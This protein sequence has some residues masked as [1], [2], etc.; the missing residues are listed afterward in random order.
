MGKHAGAVP[1]SD[2]GRAPPGTQD[3]AGGTLKAGKSFAL[4]ELCI[5]IAEGVPWFGR[6][7]V[8]Q[9]KVLY[10]NLE[11]DR[12]SCFH[13]FRDVYTAMELNPENLRNIDVWNLRGASVPMDKLAPK[14]IRR[15]AK[16]DTSPWCWTRSTKLSPATKIRPTRWRNSA[17]NSIWCAVSLGVR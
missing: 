6:F 12:A 3:A 15:A 2:R 4:I 11:L 1:G 14:L 5:S 8:A 9:G 16:A 10:I 17:I 7:R 13:R